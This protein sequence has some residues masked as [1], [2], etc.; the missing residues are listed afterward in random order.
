MNK[1]D[2]L[3][4][5][6][7]HFLEDAAAARREM[8]GGNPVVRIAPD[9]GA[10]AETLLAL[11]SARALDVVALEAANANAYLI[12]NRQGVER[13]AAGRELTLDTLAETGVAGLLFSGDPIYIDVLAAELA[14]Y[15][16]GPTVPIWEYVIIDVNLTLEEPVPIVDGWELVTPSSEELAQLVGVPSAARHVVGRRSFDLDL[17]GGL[18]M[19]RRVHPDGKPHR[20][21]I[22]YL[23]LRP[24]RALWQ[25]L[26]ALS[27][28]HNPVVHLW[29]QYDVEPGRRIDVLFD[30]VYTEPWTPDGVTEIEVV[31]RGEYEVDAADES[32][33][34]RFFVHLAPM[35]NRAVAQPVRPTRGSR[36]RA[37]R[38][39]RVGEHFLA[40]GEEAHGEGEVLSEFNADAV[41]HYVIAL[42]AVL[43]GGDSDKAELT[44]KVV[45]R[46]AVLAGVDDRDR[47]LVAETVRA[48]YTARSA[49][50]HGGEPDDIDLPS[51][52]RVVRDCVL[53]RL[54]LGDPAADGASLANLTD[55]AL[56]DHALLDEQVRRPVAAF[57][58]DVDGERPATI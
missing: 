36:E 44:R 1:Q 38:L 52:R 29:A 41:L 25:P 19:L 33:F 15:L 34:R 47:S 56:L 58:I 6:L 12:P 23:G 4:V 26:L 49:Y 28:Y 17:Y 45:Q 13:R 18:A 5:A 20:G 37:A 55:A 32:R 14:G 48:A 10:F 39:R 57:W 42:E 24:A 8:R 43:A 30:R 40:G 50:A 27:L 54:I 9:V 22:L 35:L 46:A 7:R 51:L 16:A 2:A 11:P 31:R 21:T 3:N 53:A